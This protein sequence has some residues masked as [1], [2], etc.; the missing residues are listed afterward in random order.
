MKNLILILSL[1]VSCS[2]FSQTYKSSLIT[3]YKTSLDVKAE[4]RTITIT[5][6][7]I[8]ISNVYEGIRD[9]ILNIDSTTSK[10]FLY[11]EKCLWHYCTSM[12]PI[13]KKSVKFVAIEDSKNES[14]SV[15]QIKDEMINMRTDYTLK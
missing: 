14:L 6:S 2:C 5:E 4:S 8:V 13:F 1:I 9:M 3:K 11:T 7:N 15:F 12:D 10:K